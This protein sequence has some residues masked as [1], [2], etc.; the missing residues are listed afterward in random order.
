MNVRGFTALVARP[1]TVAN[2]VVMSLASTALVYA[3][4]TYDGYKATN[5]DLDDGT[6]FVV[7]EQLGYVGRLNM[8]AQQ[9]DYRT[10]V[11]SEP[12]VLQDGRD[13][14]VGFETGM[15]TV[16]VET[17][18]FRP[19]DNGVRMRD[20]V[21]GGGVAAYIDRANGSVWTG[22]VPLVVG[23]DQPAGAVG[24]VSAGS[25]LLLSTSGRL[26]TVD[27]SE[28]VW[29]EIDLDP[30]GLPVRDDEEADASSTT[31]APTTT[32][33]VATEAD[34]TAEIEPP[35]L[36]EPEIVSPV[37]FTVDDATQLALV[38]D[39]LVFLSSAGRLAVDDI[40]AQVPGSAWALQQTGPDA[41]VVLV[42][43]D[44]GLFEVS[45]DDGAV[46]TVTAASGRPASP[47][48]VADCI[49]GAWSGEPSTWH[50]RCGDA[51]RT[52]EIPGSILS[53]E[54]V[55]QVN[56]RNV[57]LNA[58]NTGGVWAVVGESLVAVGGW[59][60]IPD[61][62]KE[63]E[64]DPQ[65]SNDQLVE[66]TCLPDQRQ[67][68]A[69]PDPD[70]GVRSNRST[71]VD[72]LANDSDQNCDPL[73]I[74]EASI[75]DDSLGTITIV[76][77]GQR[78]LFS[79][80][81]TV[82][83]W[84]ADT[85]A[86]SVQVS[87]SIVDPSNTPQSSTA[88]ITIR[89]PDDGN[90]PPL[91]RGQR[92]DGSPEPMN[93]VVESG[94][95]VRYNVL[96]DFWDPDGDDVRLVDVLLPPDAGEVTFSPD[97]VVTYRVPGVGASIQTLD[98][99]VSDGLEGGDATGELEVK[100]Q[101]QGLQIAPV[102]QNDFVTLLPGETAT[103][104]PLANDGDGNDEPLTFVLGSTEEFAGLARA[105]AWD[106]VRGLLTLTASDAPGIFEVPYAVN[107][108][109]ESVEAA[110]LVRVEPRADDAAGRPVAVPDRVVL[111]PGRLVNVD[112]LAN[113]FDP[114]GDPIAIVSD[115]STSVT[116]ERGGYRVRV[117][118]RRFL[119]VELVAPTDGSQLQ[120]P[121]TIDY[122]ISDGSIVDGQGP[123]AGQLTV[124]V[125]NSTRDQPPLA[126]P[127]TLTVRVGD[128]ATVD[129][130]ANDV[131][132]NGDQLAIA[133]LDDT[134]VQQL[135]ADGSLVAWV[136]DGDVSVR[137]GTPGTDYV[138][139]YEVI[140]NGRRASAEVRVRVLG[141]P[142]DGGADNPPAPRPTV[143]R[144]ARGSTVRVPVDAAADP[145]GDAVELVSV[146]GT[147]L[148]SSGT[149][150]TDVGGSVMAYEAASDGPTGVDSFTY[151][152]TDRFGRTGEGSVTVLV[153]DVDNAPP[154]AADDL[155]IVRPGRAVTVPVLANDVDPDDD[156]L[157]LDDL[158]FFDADGQ[159][160]AT[161]RNPDDVRVRT[162]G[163][164]AAA[165]GL[166]EI[167]APAE[168][169]PA[170]WE[171]YRVTAGADTASA[172]V[173]VVADPDAPN[174]APV[175]YG[176][177]V[178]PSEI[179]GL[180][181]LDV[182]LDRDFDPD[183]EP[184][185]VLT[186]ALP[187]AG[188][189]GIT[190][191]VAGNVVSVPLTDSPQVIVYS[192]TDADP[193]PATAYG[194]IR[195]PGLE[196]NPPTLSE[197]GRN[198]DRQSFSILA[199][200]TEPLV[201]RL[202][203][204]VEDP[205]DDEVFLTI[206]PLN[207]AGTGTAFTSEPG[208]FTFLPNPGRLDGYP[209]EVSFWVTDGDQA[210]D[211]QANRVQLKVQ[212]DVLPPGNVP[213]K[214]IAAGNVQVPILNEPVTY[215]LAALV[216]DDGEPGPLRYA[217]ESA[218]PGLQVTLGNDGTITVTGRNADAAVGSTSTIRFTVTD[219]DGTYDQPVPGVVNVTIVQTNKGA[220]TA[221]TLGPL[222]GLL[223]RPA[224]AVN[225]I[226]Q[227]T[228]PFP[229]EG[230]LDLVSVTPTNGSVSCVSEC[231]QQPIVFTPAVIGSAS[232]S[233]VVRDAI[234][235]TAQ[236]SITYVVKGEPLAPGVPSVTSVGDK[237]I[238]LT[239]TAP[240]MQGG[241]LVEYVVTAVGTGLTKRTASTAVAFDGLRNATP[242]TFTVRAVNEVGASP[243]SGASNSAIPDKVP[244]PPINVRFTG[245]GDGTLFLAWDP[246]AT[247]ADYSVITDYEINLSGVG[248]IPVSGTTTTLTRTGLVNGT[249]Y[250][251]TVRARNSAT[252]NGGWGAPSTA[253][254]SER[255]SRAP[256][257]PVGV[258]AA[259][260]GTNTIPSA[261]VTWSAPAFDGGRPIV[262]YRVCQTGTSNCQNTG[263]T[264]QATFT[265]STGTTSTFT[266]WA[267]NN[268]KAPNESAASA[269]SNSFT[270]VVQPGAPTSVSATA[271][272]RTVSASAT[273]GSNGGC[274]GTFIEY[275]INNGAS[276]QM[277]TTFSNLT[278]GVA[279]TVQARQ[280]LSNGCRTYYSRNDFSSAAI[281]AAPATP[282]GPLGQPSISA[283]V[284]GTTITWTWNANQGANGRN[285]TATVSGEC[286][287]GTI[288][289]QANNVV[290]GSQSGSCQINPGYNSGLR[291]I[292]ITVSAPGHPTMTTSATAEVGPPPRPNVSIGIGSATT[293]GTCS[294]NQGC[295]FVNIS[296]SGGTGGPYTIR[297]YGRIAGGYQLY[298][299]FSAGNGP[300]S[301]CAYSYAGRQVYVAVDG[302]VSGPDNSPVISPG[303][304]LS[305][306]IN[307]WPTD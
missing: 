116:P 131:D 101:Q 57:A 169:E 274:V 66:E 67:P 267:T 211:P 149:T 102:A 50:R 8:R 303:G 191:T 177:E 141:L 188:M 286:G 221:P 152:V 174:L 266:V 271:S 130:L 135:A 233:F 183:A 251:F 2:V 209:A 268:G 7:N 120:G 270:A 85:P 300:H 74:T 126:A 193:A 97:G 23:A 30:A 33:A 43:S 175:A 137:G 234:G 17:G 283:N 22:R 25:R 231:G 142:A 282:L 40:T 123:A 104:M 238:N 92:A 12:D 246:P 212:F 10:P 206:D 108:G 139:T 112:V 80:S 150:V 202:S 52:N 29:F 207:A 148:A 37:P 147:A 79:P 250:T 243:E 230:P 218:P 159:P 239:W 42:A 32:I 240:D 184:G 164:N 144:V 111:R 170:L 65:T 262:N 60:E 49:Y 114:G 285:W 222:D 224:T 181:V 70:I 226:A 55:F 161:P 297:C 249:D 38:G 295:Y 46:S 259:P 51:G 256:D 63:T 172:F 194:V 3:A 195:V 87:Y 168:G 146:S 124:L 196:N 118:E 136:D 77:D 145:D 166:I 190:A 61:Q 14:Y 119:Q 198:V 157:R 113:D 180:T 287:P 107:D 253:S 75:G 91:L 5:V 276:W 160:T 27:Q 90:R 81:D 84:A 171:Q 158:P 258:V 167:D 241:T 4:A 293:G 83:A 44:E 275:S 162:D 298:Q 215:R 208:S 72:V 86:A 28:S 292:S 18:G 203:E 156:E 89:H 263:T 261:Q 151:V 6:V 220:P 132:P 182:V 227:S 269:A 129:V 47:V 210:D 232:V 192:V 186:F 69:S 197:F 15:S 48:R 103:L 36:F 213:P 189:P 225:V 252:T 257:Q 117:V 272:D 255:P 165:G 279:Y 217:I 35:P 302:T 41:G 53:D 122:R 68:I 109:T 154:I 11:L 19:A 254:A 296:I 214:V 34:E 245:Y 273:A 59:S 58:V 24:R 121:F 82:R 305:N 280:T 26:L 76:E 204:I 134:V 16:D 9:F 216:E 281:S 178:D 205:E 115:G 229:E 236:G 244:D 155:M 294:D 93:A 88:T 304:T 223:N 200:A 95:S 138:F 265:A 199:D 78:L 260:N 242:Y 1:K 278:N 100:I 173:R 13:V 306:P 54:I 98:V 299:T 143:V 237:V 140:A 277:S 288:A 284:S 289:T 219:G 21:M 62:N 99:R 228:N 187:T 73:T 127:D 307:N 235:Q 133:G 179:D 106:A 264:R 31:V 291:T 290:S 201:F 153:V 247:A 301:S 71:L 96:A 128:V 248:V 64:D 105:P 185:S 94:K 20:F 110:V 176:D 39:R 45:L 56:R 163:E 125:D